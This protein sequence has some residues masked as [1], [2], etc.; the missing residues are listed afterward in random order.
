M[1]DLST[2]AVPDVGFSC[3]EPFLERPV[4]QAC[5][6][7]QF[8]SPVY[9][10]WVRQIREEKRYHRKQWEFVY[11]LQVLA[12][13]GM[14]AEGRSGVGF[15]VGLEPL[16]A[17]LAASGAAV[18]ATDLPV[19]QAIGSG[20]A[21]SGQHAPSLARLN[22][23]E[24]CP[25]DVFAERVEFRPL[26]MNTLDPSLGEFDFCWSSCA[27]E[28][29]GSIEH[30]F[31]F[32]ERSVDLLRPGG[33]AVHT[34]EFNCSSNDAT[35]DHSSTV[36]FRQR[37]LLR[38]S[39]GLAK[40]GYKIVLNFSLGDMPLDK[41]VDVSPYCTEKHLKLVLGEFVTTS[42]GLVVERPGHPDPAPVADAVR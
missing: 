36:L 24:I 39:R 34:T 29:L 3:G 12:T 22:D 28:H 17:T 20:W 40:R 30:G 41:H 18:L 10:H 16:P 15:G 33:V 14:L 1:T 19:D 42:F 2:M 23:R 21:E 8:E 31:N 38:L 7:A 6:Q 4:S 35:I 26:D 13:H 37:D 11:I 27:F 5:T 25:P 32:V 9:D